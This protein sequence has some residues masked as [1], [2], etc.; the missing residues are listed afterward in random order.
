VESSAG[1]LL[2]RLTES[3]WELARRVL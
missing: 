2:D 1:A 3:Y